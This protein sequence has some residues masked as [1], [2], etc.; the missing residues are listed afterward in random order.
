MDDTA[1][2]LGITLILGPPAMLLALGLSNVD[3]AFK[4]REELLATMI[5]GF[6][7]SGTGIGAVSLATRSGRGDS[8]QSCTVISIGSYS[9]VG[10]SSSVATEN[11]YA[12]YLKTSCEH[13]RVENN[14]V[15]RQWK[16][17]R[18]T[19]TN[20]VGAHERPVGRQKTSRK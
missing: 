14:I 10:S 20:T 13:K 5:G 9:R 19:G 16:Q 12:V 18:V 17:R 11:V 3:D 2:V 1:L 15:D 4:I 7:A 6:C 8:P